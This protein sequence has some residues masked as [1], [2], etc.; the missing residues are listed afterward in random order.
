MGVKGL[1]AEAGKAFGAR[2]V[3]NKRKSFIFPKNSGK[4]LPERSMVRF[5]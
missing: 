4:P 2:S 3:R 1:A 5:L